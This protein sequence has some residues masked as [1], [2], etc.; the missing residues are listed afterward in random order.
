MRSSEKYVMLIGIAQTD[1]AA[2]AGVERLMWTQL[3]LISE[4]HVRD[5]SQ[6]FQI[7]VLRESVEC[8]QRGHNYP[9][10]GGIEIAYIPCKTIHRTGC[11]A[12]ASTLTRP[13]QSK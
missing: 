13:W 7:H 4:K 6:Q 9:L 10:R 1:R 2:T 12:Q 8:Q 11:T 5:G 3:S